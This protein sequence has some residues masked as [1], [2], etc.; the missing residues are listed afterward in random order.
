[1]RARSDLAV[2]LLC[3][4]AS[5][6]ADAQSYP[7]PVP[8]KRVFTVPN[9]SKAN[10]SLHIKAHNGRDL[11]TLQCHSAGYEGDLDFDY[12]GDFECRLSLSNGQNAYSTLLTEDENQSRDWESR[13]RFFAASLRGECAKVPEFGAVRNFTLRGMRLS[14]RI[15]DPMFQGNKLV[16]L[17]LA[18]VVVVPDP[19]AHRPIADIV[20]FPKSGVPT[21][22]DL[23]KYFVNSAKLASNH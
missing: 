23:S 16:S 9:V 18:V 4:F 10:I 22:C 2:V 11:Y 5:L 20:P 21:S 19:N 6:N 7:A 17:R 8:I 1:M 14:L 13:G 15:L 3:C 12:S